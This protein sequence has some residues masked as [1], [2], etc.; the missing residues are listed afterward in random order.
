MNVYAGGGEAPEDGVPRRPHRGDG[1][2]HRRWHHPA[3]RR[4]LHGTRPPAPRAPH[5]IPRRSC[6]D[7]FFFSP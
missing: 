6:V 1:A 5:T 7:L 4:D 3:L 2:Q